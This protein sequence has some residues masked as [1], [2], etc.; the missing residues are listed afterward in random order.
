MKQ[1]NI[2]KICITM[3]VIYLLLLLAAC[4]GSDAPATEAPANSSSS[5]TSLGDETAPADESPTEAAPEADAA[6]SASEHFDAGEKYFSEGNYEQAIVEFTRVTELAPEQY[7]GFFNLAAAYTRAGDLENAIAVWTEAIA[8]NPADPNAYYSRGTVY[9][10]MHSLEDA[11]ADQTKAIEL[12]PEL[13]KAYRDRGV[14]YF[15]LGTDN[16][17]SQIWEQQALPDYNKAIELDPEDAEAYNFRGWLLGN[18]SRLDEAVADFDQAINLDPNLVQAYKNRGYTHFTAGNYEQAIADYSTVLELAPTA[19]DVHALE[20]AHFFRALAAMEL[21]DPAGYAGIV[22]DLGQVLQI[23]EV[24]EFRRHA[25]TTLEQIRDTSDDAALR[26]QAAAAL[27]AAG[28]DSAAAAGQQQADIPPGNTIRVDESVS[29]GNDNAHIFLGASGGMILVSVEPEPGLDVAVAIQDT[30]TREMVASANNDPGKETLSFQV[31]SDIRSGLYR[32]IIGSINDAQGKYTA[33]FTGSQGVSFGLQP[34]YRV[35]GRLPEGTFLTYTYSGPQGQNLQLTASPLPA[36]SI[37][38]LLTIYNLDDMDTALLEVN[39]TGVGESET[40]TLALP[41]AG[42]GTYVIAV[43]E[44]NN[45][46]GDFLLTIAT[47][48]ESPEPK[49]ADSS[50]A[51]TDPAV[52]VQALFDAAAAGDFAALQSLCDPQGENDGD[53]QMICD[54]ATDT[55]NRS[56]FVEIF[57]NGKI[58]GQARIS[59][60]KAEVPFLFGPDGQDEETMELIN[61]NGQWYLFS[62]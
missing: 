54:T 34:D 14:A 43:K 6:G 18:L 19:D 44:A 16:Q 27:E 36:G 25:Q 49:A 2:F 26:Q 47:D 28:I 20:D 40:L 1:N 8:L 4:G 48:S 60:D 38:L 51:A 56:D 21:N 45:Q 46:A 32:I 24:P 41:A 9:F 61:R 37:D 11:I 13:A 12:D 5:Q 58:N 50:L 31:P 39:D 35:A 33:Y 52:V 57:A 15:G 59:G 22:A 53:T 29:P 3:L 42:L 55:T 30:Q 23:S 10:D 62:F 7:Q 17:D